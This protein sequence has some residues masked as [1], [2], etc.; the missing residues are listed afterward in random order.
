[1]QEKSNIPK[2]DAELLEIVLSNSRASLN[3]LAETTKLSKVTADKKLNELQKSGVIKRFFPIINFSKLNYETPVYFISLKNIDKEKEEKI[4]EFMVSQKEIGWCT[5]CLGKWD[6]AFASFARYPSEIY[7]LL[8]RILNKF[9]NN[10]SDYNIGLVSKVIDNRSKP[11]VVIDIA[12]AN[13]RESYKLSKKERL[14]LEILDENCRVSFT[15]IVRKTKVSYKT[16]ISTLK[17]LQEQGILEKFSAQVDYAPYGYHLFNLLLRFRKRDESRISELIEY[18]TT[19][20]GMHYG[21][22]LVGYY[23]FDIEFWLKEELEIEKIISDLKS[24]FGDIIESIEHIVYLHEYKLTYLP[25][26]D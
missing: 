20:K 24:K 6:I 14:I 4:I 3:S 8:Q 26:K 16:I 17:R 7:E 19:I 12:K 1:M 2:K 15:D 5:K 9:P 10:I 13:R 11:A 21:I 25:P 23:D 22:R 18:L